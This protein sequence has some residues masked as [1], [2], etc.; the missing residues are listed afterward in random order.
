[1]WLYYFLV[2]NIIFNAIILSFFAK[3][4]RFESIY[5]VLNMGIFTF[6]SMF[7]S[8][9]VGNDT[10]V[11]TNLFY[12][13][14]NSS[15]L[16]LYTKRFEVGYVILNRALGLISNN[17]QIVFIVTSFY[18]FFI[19][20]KFIYKYSNM[21]WLSVF[22]FFSLRYFDLSMSGT[23]QMLAIA[24]ILLSYD[25]ILKKK[26]LKFIIC[27]LVASLFHKAAI[28]FFIAY[29][30]SKCKL[31]KKLLL[32]TFG[33]TLIIFILFNKVLSFLL[34]LFPKYSYYVGGTYLDG[35]ARLGIIVELAVI[36]VVLIAGETFTKKPFAYKGYIKSYEHQIQ[37]VFLLISV[38]I[39]F[40]ALRATI[41]SRFNNIYGIFSIIYLPNSI[42]KISD[43]ALR[44]VVII[45][46]LILFFAYSTSVQ[47]FRP[48]WQST[49]PFK[50]FWN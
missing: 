19:T 2:I 38:A 16:T 31:N 50:F 10:Q 15:D 36:V 30:L 23:R 46:T 49:Y 42:N 44:F 20:G 34:I 27:V 9:S 11:Y 48:E 40:V 43:K 12:N 47:V 8:S 32:S 1:M 4:K 35:V 18:I 5:L 39:M 41:F 29:P 6:L 45:C 25:F 37:S 17:H 28:I 22:L 7:K 33:I 13:I 21:V 3:G 24:T 26:L 14:L